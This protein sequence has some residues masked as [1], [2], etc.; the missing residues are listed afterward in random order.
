MSYFTIL[1]TLKH[2]LELKALVGSRHG[3]EGKVERYY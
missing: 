1:I 2:G 3:V